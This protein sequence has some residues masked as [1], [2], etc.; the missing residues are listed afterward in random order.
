MTDFRIER[1]NL[2]NISELMKTGEK[3]QASHRFLQIANRHAEMIPLL[4]EFIAEIKT[5]SGCAA[6]GM[7]ILDRKGNIPFVAYTGFSRRFYEKES[8]LSIRNGDTACIRVICNRIDPAFPFYTPGGSFFVNGTSRFPEATAAAGCKEPCSVC[9]SY[10]Y[11][12]VALIPI[13]L[14]DQILGLIH[15]ADPRDDKVPQEMVQILEDGA[16]QL[17][18]AIKRVRAEE[19]LRKSNEALEERVKIRTAELA[20]INRELV[21]Q[22]T[23]REQAESALRKSENELRLL[24][25]RLLSAEEKERKRIARE[26]HDGIGQALSAIKFGVENALRSLQREPASTEVDS[27]K[28]IVPFTQKT[29]EEVRRIVK[30]LRPSILD[31]LGIIATINWFCREFKSLYAPIRLDHIINVEED[32][33]PEHLKT[34]IYRILQEAL[35]NVAKHSRAGRVSIGLEKK[36]ALLVFGI[37]DDGIGFD[38]EQVVSLERSERGVGLASMRERTELTGGHFFISSG[39][40]TGTTIRIV[41]SLAL[42]AQR[43]ST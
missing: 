18:A 24:S 32:D 28:Q 39:R 15:V 35:N 13:R 43:V 4:D 14:G 10:G 7:R 16:M 21:R 30:D 6:V 42:G 9:R 2:L 38:P 19:E 25:G 23:E 31:D 37:S 11:E 27:L 12:S 8:P 5:L 22:M 33:V 34:V 40:Q 3:L 36:D 20:A 26:L 41:W 1:D 29:I 17:G